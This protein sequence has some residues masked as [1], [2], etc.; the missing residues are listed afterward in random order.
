[1]SFPHPSFLLDLERHVRSRAFNWIANLVI[2]LKAER[3]ILRGTTHSFYAK[4]LAQ[5]GVRELLPDIRLENAIQVERLPQ[6]ALA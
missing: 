3:V 2:E 5:Q 1:M 6:L 4:Q